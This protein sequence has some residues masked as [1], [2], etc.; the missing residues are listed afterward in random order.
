MS[1]SDFDED[2][3]PMEVADFLK[4]EGIPDEFA[5]VLSC[6]LNYVSIL[7]TLALQLALGILKLPSC[8]ER[9]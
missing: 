1:I 2:W 4:E 5:D 7:C 9:S 3:T 8:Q 6:E